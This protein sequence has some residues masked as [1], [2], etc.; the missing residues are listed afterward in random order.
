MSTLYQV[1]SPLTDLRAL[2]LCVDGDAILLLGDTC[3][4][5][6][7]WQR[8]IQESSVILRLYVRQSDLEQR[9][10]SDQ[11]PDIHMDTDAAFHAVSDTAWVNLTLKHART[12]SWGAS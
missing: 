10:L 3:Y 4:Q 2:E 8:A 1:S 9:A 5:L 11:N 7:Q 12:L 6:P